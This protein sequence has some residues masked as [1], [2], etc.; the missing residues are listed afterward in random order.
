MVAVVTVGTTVYMVALV[1]FVTVDAI[2]IVTLV[3]IV[4][5]FYQGYHCF[6][7]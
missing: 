4:A 6:C 1:T 3:I 5:F 7:G 2:A